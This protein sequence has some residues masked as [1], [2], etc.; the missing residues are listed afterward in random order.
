MR[1]TREFDAP[2]FKSGSC[3]G[4]VTPPPTLVHN[5]MDTQQFLIWLAHTPDMCTCESPFPRGRDGAPPG[6]EWSFPNTRGTRQ[7]LWTRIVD[8]RM[9]HAWL[10][11]FA[12]VLRG[13]RYGN[14]GG[15]RRQV[16][17]KARSPCDGGSVAASVQPLLNGSLYKIEHFEKNK[18]VSFTAGRGTSR[19]ASSSGIR[20]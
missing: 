4:A 5:W 13:E 19:S 11:P 10:S 14:P 18:I 9:A 1:A 15:F 6:Q 2:A 8:R 16:G 17:W 3:Y 7:R 12:K 20:G